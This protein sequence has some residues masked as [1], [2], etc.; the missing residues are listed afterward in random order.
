MNNMRTKTVL[1]LLA[2]LVLL[3]TFSLGALSSYV[4]LGGA[5]AQ[6]SPGAPAI[7]V[8]PVVTATVETSAPAAT[9]VV[10]ADLTGR[11]QEF[12]Q[13]V[14][15]LRK[16]SY[17]RPVDDQKLVDGAIQGMMQAL[18]DPYTR[19]ETPDQNA[20][21][22][23]QMQGETYGGIGAYVEVVDNLPTIAAPI[24]NTPAS[25]AGI[26]AKDTILAVDGRDVTTLSADQVAA[27]IRGPEG[28][29]VRLTLQ[30]G[31]AAPFDVEITRAVINVPQVAT[32]VRP[33]GIAVISVSIFGDQTT[34]QLDAGIKQLKAANAKGIIL[35]LRDNGGGYVTSAQQMIGRFVSPEMGKKYQDAAL[36]Y[37][38][39]QDGSEDELV[40][41]IRDGESVYDLPLVVLVNGGT[42]SA[43]EITAGALS[44]YGRAILIGEQTFGKG[45]VQNVHQ[46]D[47]G[48]SARITIAHWL[49]PKKRDINPRP[50][51]TPVPSATA[52]ALPTLT[53][54]PIGG[55]PTALPNVTATPVPP[56]ILRD[57]GITPDIEVLRTDADFT[58][59][60]DPQLDRAVQYLLTGK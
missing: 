5:P 50:T 12:Y 57:R 44:D 7:A 28:S 48:S 32:E 45:S 51:A 4:F 37:S 20:Q 52:T 54:T 46:F 1:S 8:P 38:K 29:T 53:P 16:E 25:H 26:R 3:A 17:Y 13:I 47:N 22:Q 14:D 15:L 43:S 55:I 18:N 42:A 49:S 11:M 33:D 34:A 19:F 23:Q 58:H 31:Q 60:R 41:I 56:V 30:R 2:V 6:A 10:P 27:L 59:G 9:P 39:A 24:P 40:P 35:D 36:F 21:T